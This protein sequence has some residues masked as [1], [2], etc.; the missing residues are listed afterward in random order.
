MLISVKPLEVA[1]GNS[2]TGRMIEV[3]AVM[4]QA[5]SNEILNC[6][7]KTLDTRNLCH[8]SQQHDMFA[9]VLSSK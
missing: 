3:D 2:R 4:L 1:R 6:M 5:A 8:G 7:S 9:H